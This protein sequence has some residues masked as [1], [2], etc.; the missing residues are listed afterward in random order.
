[1]K[2]YK[3]LFEDPETGL[4]VPIIVELVGGSFFEVVERYRSEI[5]LADNGP[6]EGV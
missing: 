3:I 5:T 2:K 1:M 6:L 4:D